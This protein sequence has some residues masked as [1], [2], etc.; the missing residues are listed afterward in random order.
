MFEIRETK[1]LEAGIYFIA[2]IVKDYQN[3][4]WRGYAF[5][6]LANPYGFL[7]IS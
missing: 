5:N 4:V 6:V 2:Q 1:K 3:T 7:R